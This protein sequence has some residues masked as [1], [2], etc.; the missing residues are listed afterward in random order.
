M[1]PIFD[2]LCKLGSA[3]RVLDIGCGTG[4]FTQDF[5]RKSGC[6]LVGVD[7]SDYGL[8]QARE[9]GFDETYLVRDLSGDSIPLPDRSFDLILC[10]DFLEHLM[11]PQFV[12][13]EAARLLKP[14][15]YFFV[16]VP[17]HFPLYFR[18]KFLFTNRID[19]QNYFPE[20]KE[21]NFPHIR[22]FTSRGLS[23]LVEQEGF[24]VAKRYSS[25]F[26]CVPGLRRFPMGSRMV[27]WLADRNPDQFATALALLAQKKS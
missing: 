27:K 4:F 6:Y 25:F 13:R 8:A 11:D 9:R 21:W 16:L 15:G 5:K 3:P 10:K 22:F 1:A 18:F 17:N 26:P 20:A 12:V 14:G 24:K 2:D 23:A 7:G 19:T